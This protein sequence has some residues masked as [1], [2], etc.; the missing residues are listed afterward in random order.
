MLRVRIILI[1]LVILVPV[2]ALAGAYQD[3]A[4]VETAFQNVKSFHAVEQFS[5]GKS[6]TVDYVAP[7]RW[8]LENSPKQAEVIIGNDVYIVS[9]GKTSHMPFR[10]GIF[11]KIVSH[12]SKFGNDNEIKETAQDLGMQ[13]LNGERVHVYSFKSHGA[14]DTMYVGPG[15]LPVENVVKSGKHTTTI[16]YSE[17]NRPITIEP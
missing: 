14:L 5:N 17:Y 15:S 1:A 6:S 11:R 12:F 8:R 7:D 9:N 3:L 4:K 16:T 13:P 2:S 10:G